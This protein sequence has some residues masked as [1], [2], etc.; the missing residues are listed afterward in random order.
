MAAGRVEPLRVPTNCLD[1][2][3][4]QIVAELAPDQGAIEPAEI[5]ALFHAHA[6][7]LR[8]LLFD[9]YDLHRRRNARPRTGMVGGNRAESS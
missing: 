7:N 4:Q 6:G 1:V 9:C 2:L 5:V 3:A 8:E